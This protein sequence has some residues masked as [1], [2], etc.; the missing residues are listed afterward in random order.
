MDSLQQAVTDTTTAAT[1]ATSGKAFIAALVQPGPPKR[2]L[3]GI[4]PTQINIMSPGL[5]KIIY[6]K[7]GQVYLDMTMNNIQELVLT[8]EERDALVSSLKAYNTNAINSF[9]QVLSTVILSN[10]TVLRVECEGPS[11]MV[12]LLEN[13]FPGLFQKVM[14]TA[15]C[16]TGTTTLELTVVGDHFQT[17]SEPLRNIF[18]RWTVEYAP[19]SLDVVLDK[20]RELFLA[21]AV[22][23]AKTMQPT[24]TVS[25]PTAT[26][27]RLVSACILYKE[28]ANTRVK[29]AGLLIQTNATLT[30]TLPS[31]LSPCS[32]AS[33]GHAH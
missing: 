14:F 8:Q 27:A 17:V 16:T 24:C 10:D 12:G 7:D 4:L 20:E 13:P 19:S 6:S 29:M 30:L 25:Y 9:E 3:V 23:S 31:P 1:N 32:C 28:P 21:A 15:D 33:Y 5:Q 22:A 18:R 11:L 2:Q 26:F